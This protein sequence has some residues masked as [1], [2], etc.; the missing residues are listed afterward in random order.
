MCNGYYDCY[1]H[2]NL[3]ICEFPLC[4]CIL[5]ISID[6]DFL[7]VV[8]CQDRIQYVGHSNNS[9]VETN[10]IATNLLPVALPRLTIRITPCPYNVHVGFQVKP[11]L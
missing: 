8:G 9:V 2:L 5:L 10:T 3:V 11:N 4:V 7:P 1:I 6:E